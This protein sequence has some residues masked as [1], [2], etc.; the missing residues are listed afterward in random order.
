[1][2]AV[3]KLAGQEHDQETRAAAQKA[4]KSFF[5][6]SAYPRDEI[7]R[8]QK[9]CELGSTVATHHP[10]LPDG[11]IQIKATLAVNGCAFFRVEPDSG[12]GRD[13]DARQ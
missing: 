3:L 1:M 10:R 8:V 9:L 5:A 12:G 6:P 11:Q 2:P 4:I 13:E 7:D